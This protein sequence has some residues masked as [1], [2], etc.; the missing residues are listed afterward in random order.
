[1]PAAV[2]SHDDGVGAWQVA[3][4][5]IDGDGAPLRSVPS[6]ADEQASSSRQVQSGIAYLNVS[7]HRIQRKARK[8]NRKD[9]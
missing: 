2:T 8:K 5:G 6:T 9:N 4:V 1:M 3:E 7:L